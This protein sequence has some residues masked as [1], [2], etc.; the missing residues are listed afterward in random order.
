MCF[1]FFFGGEGEGGQRGEVCGKGYR[2][3][4]MKRKIDSVSTIIYLSQNDNRRKTET[5]P[6]Q[7][8]H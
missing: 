8:A 2:E 6:K 7:N 4:K 3:E 5:L 1:F